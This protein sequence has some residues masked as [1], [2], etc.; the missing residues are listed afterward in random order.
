MIPIPLAT[1]NSI[2]AAEFSQLLQ[3]IYEH[4]P[5][6]AERAAAARPFA[7]RF[8]LLDAMQQVVA[9]A[10]LDEQLGL[11]RAHPELAGKAAVRGE[12]TAE[13]TREQAG[14]GLAHCSQEEFDRLHALNSAYNQ[15]FGFP[16]ILSVRGHDRAS[17]LQHFQRRAA[18]DPDTER[19]TALRE[20][21][22]IAE[23]RLLDRVAEP[24]GSFIIAMADRLAQHTEVPGQLTCSYLSDPHRAVAR[25]LRDWMWAVGLDAHID[26][27]GNVVGQL[28]CGRPDA[29]RLITGSH[30]DTVADAGR[31]DGRL[32]VLLPIAVVE[33]L[34]HNGLTLAVDLEIVGFGDEEGLRFDS[35][36]LGSRALAGQFD[37]SLLELRDRNGISLREALADAGL[38]ADG[39]PALARDPATVAGYVEVH[40]EQGPQLLSEARALGV[41]TAINGARRFLITVTGE[42]GHAGTVPMALRRDA[43]A[44]AAE[45]LLYV[46]RRC[47][48]V[49]GLVGTVG[50]LQ[51]PGGAVNVIP[52]RCELSLDIRAPDDAQRDAAV[53]DIQ[54]K[55]TAI[56]ASRRVQFTLQPVLNSPATPCDAELL[57][58][59]TA[60]IRAVTSDATP[61]HLPSGAGHD[62][63]AM[64]ALCP[65]AM[66]FV[67]CGNGG[68][69]HHP[70]ETLS[71]DDADAAALVFHHFV[72]HFMS[73]A[74]N[75]SHD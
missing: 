53:A 32:G 69:S 67:R 18:A 7:S 27:I 38:D 28:R 35:T 3:G 26:A 34:R 12:L 41:V 31:Y 46:E 23:F 64:A 45:L 30:Y 51:V 49:P 66:L 22:R 8:A 71:V 52:G 1:L 42:A 57:N 75:P 70:A 25:Q 50:R 19:A 63:V 44:A 37:L 68:I 13:S 29:R 47:A 43:A 61:R 54:A 55:I 2:T 14:A 16:F 5:W 59:L 10:T 40:I 11:I 72:S 48:R 62:A 24:L 17:I 60:S 4:S 9:S 39:I 74:T 65:V 56:G 21:G 58:G 6:I 15:R 20:I 36:Y 73:P 33:Q